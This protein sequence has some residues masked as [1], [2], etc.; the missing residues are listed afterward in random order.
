LGPSQSG[1]EV[2]ASQHPYR[3]DLSGETVRPIKQQAEQ[4]FAPH[5]SSAKGKKKMEQ[6]G[7]EDEEV[8]SSV[9]NEVIKMGNNVVVMG[10]CFKRPIIIN[11]S[12][13]A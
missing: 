8:Q 2:R 12:I 1:Q 6:S 11:G 5:I 13:Q 10:D 9:V 4:G 7:P 3:S